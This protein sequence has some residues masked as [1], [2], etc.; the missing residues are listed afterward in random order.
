M[1]FEGAVVYTRA[2]RVGAQEKRMM[3]YM[4]IPEI[5]VSECSDYRLL[6]TLLHIY[7]VGRIDVERRGIKLHLRLELLR[8]IS[9]MTQLE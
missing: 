3:I 6:A 9:K 8:V 5:K 1:D 7:Q 2:F 4:R